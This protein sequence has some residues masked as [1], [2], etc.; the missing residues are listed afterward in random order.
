MAPALNVG[1][2]GAIFHESPECFTGTFDQDY[3]IAVL[4]QL[5]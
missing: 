3:M 5:I 1:S 2:T 4:E